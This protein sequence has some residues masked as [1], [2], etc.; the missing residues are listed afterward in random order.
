MALKVYR[1]RG[2]IIPIKIVLLSKSTIN[3]TIIKIMVVVVK[4]VVEIMGVLVVSTS[5]ACSALVS[6]SP[7]FPFPDSLLAV[8]IL[9][10][11]PFLV[12]P[13]TSQDFII[14]KTC[15]AS[16]LCTS[17]NLFYD[18]QAICNATTLLIS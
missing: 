4:G 12:F 6:I 17:S 11:F 15:L 13:T 1:L 5:L 14:C 10:V 2:T 18:F 16:T 7:V 9:F 8:S 3:N